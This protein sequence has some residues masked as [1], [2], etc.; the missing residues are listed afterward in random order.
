MRFDGRVAVD[1]HG[2]RLYASPG[3][4]L[5]SALADG[6]VQ[7]TKMKECPVCGDNVELNQEG[8]ISLHHAPATEPECCSGSLALDVAAARRT[9]ENGEHRID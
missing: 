6:W 3:Y 9:P 8:L 5:D 2:E 4:A 1:K 7:V